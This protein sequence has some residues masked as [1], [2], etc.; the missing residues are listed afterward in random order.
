[1]PS[2]H[3]DFFYLLLLS[4]V[5]SQSFSLHSHFCRLIIKVHVVIRKE[6]V[7]QNVYIYFLFWGGDREEKPEETEELLWNFSDS[8]SSAGV[9]G[10]GTSGV[11][12]SVRFHFCVTYVPYIQFL[13]LFSSHQIALQLYLYNWWKKA[14][15]IWSVIIREWI[16]FFLSFLSLSALLFLP[17]I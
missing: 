3:P 5:L 16:C 14:L 1:M 6:A 12:Y 15:L 17:L 9:I 7:R 4:E 10:I 11:C 13:C 8:L 2:H